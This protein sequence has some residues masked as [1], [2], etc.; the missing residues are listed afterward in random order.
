MYFLSNDNRG[1]G[2]QEGGVTTIRLVMARISVEL[3]AVQRRCLAQPSNRMNYQASNSPLSAYSA[4]DFFRP[5]L[6]L[7]IRSSQSVTCSKCVFV[8]L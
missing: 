6:L 2:Y 8:I 7:G 4:R 5:A 3:L 1:G